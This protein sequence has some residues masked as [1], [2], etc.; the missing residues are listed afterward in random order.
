MKAMKRGGFAEG[1]IRTLLAIG[2]AD[3]MLNQDEFNR[4]DEIARRHPQ[5]KKMTF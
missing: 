1:L 5:L 2:T 3:Q 4:F